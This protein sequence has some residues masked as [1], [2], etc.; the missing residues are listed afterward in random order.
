MAVSIGSIEEFDP[1]KEEWAQYAERMGHYF[2][3]NGVDTAEK[4]RSA[5]LAAIRAST[6][7]L[8]RN[9]IAPQ[10]LTPE[11]SG[12]KRVFCPRLKRT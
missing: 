4:K 7:K 3:A 12:N 8:L 11:A 9:L 2:D 1:V 5:F 6:Y 10:K